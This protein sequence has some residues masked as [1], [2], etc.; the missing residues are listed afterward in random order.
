MR[1]AQIKLITTYVSLVT[2]QK[3]ENAHDI[4]LSFL[5]YYIIIITAKEADRWICSVIT[6]RLTVD[7]RLKSN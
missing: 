7:N 6:Y 2:G 5:N 1:Y 4:F 3:L